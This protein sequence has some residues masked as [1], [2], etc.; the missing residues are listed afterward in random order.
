MLDGMSFFALASK[1]LDWLAAR[2][3]VVSENIANANTP[4]FRAKEVSGFEA[5]LAGRQAGIATTD[6][7]HITSSGGRHETTRVID[8]PVAWE[9]SIDGNSV[10]LEQQTVK[11]SEISES[12]RLATQLYRKGHELLT[13]SATGLR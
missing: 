13:M 6:P 3:K 7:R 9:R 2:Q 12:Y 8:D 4:G 10:V 5:L 1:R 11:A